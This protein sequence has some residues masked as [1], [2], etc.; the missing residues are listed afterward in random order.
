[1][2]ISKVQTQTHKKLPLKA[3]IHP[4]LTIFRFKEEQGHYLY[5]KMKK[6]TIKT[7]KTSKYKKKLKIVHRIN[8]NKKMVQNMTVDKTSKQTSA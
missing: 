8:Q 7:L 4:N 5:P 6:V 1:M 2:K 3:S